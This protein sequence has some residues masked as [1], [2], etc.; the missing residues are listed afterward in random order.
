MIVSAFNPETTDLEKTYLSSFGNTS[1]TI[2]N[3]KNND[4]F[5]V[6]DYVLVGEMGGEKSE[7]RKISAVNANKKAITVDAL[8]FDHNSDTT[9]Y[10]LEFNKIRF[11]RRTSQTGTPT[12]QSTLDIDVDNA[13]NL[14]RWDDAGS[15]VTYWYQTSWY[16]SDTD[17]ESELSDPIQATGYERKTIGS[18]VDGVV[19]RVRDVDYSV[20]SFEEYIDIA[21]EVGDDLITQAMKPYVFLKKTITL[22]ATEGQNY[23][24]LVA[25]AADAGFIF[26]KYDYVEVNTL[27]GG[28]TRFRRFEPLSFEDFQNRYNNSPVVTGDK[29]TDI[30]FDDETKRLYIYPTPQEDLTGVIVLHFYKYF[31]QL[32]SAGDFI[33]T[34]NPTI[35]RYKMMAEYYSAKS[36]VDKQ[37][38]VLAE[39]Y[40]TKYG[41]EI[42]KMQR[43]NR[44]DIG[45][46]R[47]FR[48]PRLYRRRRFRL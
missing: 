17:D 18:V 16:N 27:T 46:P 37:W 45:T 14:T 12:L 40:E 3:V 13:D 11:Y 24:D 29:I 32:K 26:W 30:A 35:Y 19:R 33:E 31:T 38:I 23:I 5:A 42:V 4:K 47:S 7:I 39:K 25:A 22:D 9:I 44:I 10:R 6:N 41:N 2:L 28:D 1:D 36:E 15:L 20:L 21:Q 48:P 34:P 8:L 43:A